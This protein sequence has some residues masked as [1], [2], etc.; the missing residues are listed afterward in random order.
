MSAMGAIIRIRAVTRRTLD[1]CFAAVD[2]NRMG[3]GGQRCSCNPVASATGTRGREIPVRSGSGGNAAAVGVAVGRTRTGGTAGVRPCSEGAVAEIEGAFKADVD[4]AVDMR[5][6]VFDQPWICPGRRQSGGAV[7][8]GGMTNGARVGFAHTAGSTKMFLMTLRIVLVSSG[9]GHGRRGVAMA[10]VTSLCIADDGVIAK[11]PGR[12]QRN[13]IIANNFGAAGIAFTTVTVTIGVAAFPGIAATGRINR[14]QQA[15]SGRQLI[16]GEILIA[17]WRCHL[18]MGRLRRQ[19]KVTRIAG[20]NTGT[21]DV[22]R[23]CVPLHQSASG[24]G[25]MGCCCFTF[26]T[27]GNSIQRVVMIAVRVCIAAITGCIEST[28][29]AKAVTTDSFVGRK[30]VTV[31]AGSDVGIVLKA[32][33]PTVDLMH[34]TIPANH[35]DQMESGL[36]GNGLGGS[37][38]DFTIPGG[39][40]RSIVIPGGIDRAVCDRFFSRKR[41]RSD[42]ISQDI[43]VAVADNDMAAMAGQAADTFAAI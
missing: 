26:V 31:A 38:A 43:D 20:L 7:C 12:G 18:I 35:S 29:I 24:M 13:G 39:R 34:V 15:V 36:F 41:C 28:R 25:V 40:A 22:I 9:G 16:P 30:S 21:K 11:C 4:H 19:I 27:A 2:M 17:S 37:V 10:E 33:S 23:R 32:V 42:T 6:A 8:G 14:T 5:A 1:L 3:T